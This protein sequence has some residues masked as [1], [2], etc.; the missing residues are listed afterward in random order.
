MDFEQA[1][2]DMDAKIWVDAD[3]V[4]IEGCMMDLG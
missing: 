2:G 1:I 3:H 4:S